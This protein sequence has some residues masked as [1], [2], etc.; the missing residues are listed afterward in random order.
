MPNGTD[1]RRLAVWLVGA[2]FSACA[3]LFLACSCLGVRGWAATGKYTAPP[4]TDESSHFLE[5]GATTID[6]YAQGM[7]I[8]LDR[9]SCAIAEFPRISPQQ[10][11]AVIVEPLGAFNDAQQ[12]S[13]MGQSI[14]ALEVLSSEAGDLPIVTAQNLPL[15][16]GRFPG[17]FEQHRVQVSP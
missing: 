7:P 13:C 4:A 6:V 9:H 16:H 3:C 11:D 8:L 5:K 2:M 1:T 14:V 10:F 17:G 15:R 12:I